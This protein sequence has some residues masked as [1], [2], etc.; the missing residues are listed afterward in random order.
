MVYIPKSHLKNLKEITYK[1]SGNSPLIKSVILFLKPLQKCLPPHFIGTNS[2]LT[3]LFLSLCSYL[4]ISQGSLLLPSQSLRLLLVFLLLLL[5]TSLDLLNDLPPTSKNSHNFLKI[6]SKFTTSLLSLTLFSLV[7]LHLLNQGL[8]NLLFILLS[9]FHSLI[10]IS[11]LS[12]S[13]HN[14]IRTNLNYYKIPEIKFLLILSVLLSAIW[15]PEILLLKTYNCCIMDLIVVIVSGW[16]IWVVLL[17]SSGMVSDFGRKGVNSVLPIVMM[18][19][20]MYYWGKTA[21]GVEYPELCVGLHGLVFAVSVS[22]IKTFTA[23]KVGF[24]WIQ[25]EFLI[26]F[27]FVMQDVH[28]QLLPDWTAFVVLCG[29]MGVRYVTMNISIIRQ[30]SQYLE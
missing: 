30:V 24:E 15:G 14:Y 4:L 19:T 26:E 2:E 22:K 18:N 9:S 17:Y 16:G 20:S 13:Q 6:F 29:V 12:E 11:C 5:E 23:A 21:L 25:P 3:R 1:P 8:S 10:F 27:G 7:F 28:N